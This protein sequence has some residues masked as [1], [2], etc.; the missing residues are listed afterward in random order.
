MKS[1]LKGSIISTIFS[2][3]MALSVPPLWAQ[4]KDSGG[5]K[6]IVTKELNQKTKLVGTFDL[7]DEGTKKVRNLRMMSIEEPVKDKDGQRV[8]VKFRDEATGDMV[9]VD[10]MLKD[11]K[12][13]E[14]KITKVEAPKIETKESYTD[15][16]VKQ[17]IDEY[18]AQQTKF[19]EYLMFFD[20][21]I[22][23]M[24]KL[25]LTGYKNDYRHFGI[26]TIETA[27]FKD[28][29]TGD[30]L[31]MDIHVKVIKGVL[32]VESLKIRKVAKVKP[33]AS[34]PKA[35]AAAK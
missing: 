19:T 8:P 10:A 32:E 25:Q 23:N 20:P 3:F 30:T 21:K 35:E 13:T 1:I 34:A 28:I 15:A 27:D 6:D 17:V 22:E 14:W 33:A 9:T 31:T 5:I 26:L 4:G 11:N 24:R 12:V 29:D 18:L 2:I 7:F 16:E